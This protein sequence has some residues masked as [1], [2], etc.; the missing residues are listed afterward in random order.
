MALTAQEFK[1]Q[2]I[3]RKPIRVRHREN[4]PVQRLLGAT[5]GRQ[6]KIETILSE[7]PS[8]MQPAPLGTLMVKAVPRIDA[9]RIVCQP[10]PRETRSHVVRQIRRSGVTA[11]IGHL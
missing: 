2:P 11:V 1:A 5:N 7:T 8:A 6:Q 9:A 3:I 10:Q 4:G